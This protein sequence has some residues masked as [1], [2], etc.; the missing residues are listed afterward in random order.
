MLPFYY[1][2][3]VMSNTSSTYRK[4]FNA[5]VTNELPYLVPLMSALEAALVNLNEGSYRH[6]ATDG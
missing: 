1:E 5:F 6:I 3:S 4:K 2:N